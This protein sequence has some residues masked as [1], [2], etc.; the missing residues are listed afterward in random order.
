MEEDLLDRR[1]YVL[2]GF[3]DCCPSDTISMYI[4]SCSH[5]AEHSWEAVSGD[6][7]VVT[8][9]EDIGVSGDILIVAGQSVVE[10]CKKHGPQTF[11][12]VVLTGGGNLN[13]KHIAHIPGPVK[14][15]A[16][17]LKVLQLCESKQ[18]ATV[19]I[20]TIGIGIDGCLPE[21]FAKAMLQGVKV[22]LLCTPFSSLKT[23]FI[24]AFED[25]NYDGIKKYFNKPSNSKNLRAG[26]QITA[27]PVITH[28]LPPNQVKI[29]DALIELKKGNITAETVEAIVNSTNED[30]NLKNG[31]SGA[32]LYAAGSAVEDECAKI[33]PL[34]GNDARLTSGGSLQCDF[35]I[36]I[37][38][39]RNI[40]QAVERV[41]NVLKHCESRWITS[42]SFPAIG[43]GGGGM[44]FPESVTAL[45]LGIKAHLS[46]HEFSA[47]KQ[48]F[49][50]VDQVQA[51]QE[52]Q[53]VL[54]SWTRMTQDTADDDDSSNASS[55]E[56]DCSA[57][58]A[59]IGPV[60]VKLLCG[61]ITEEKTDAIVS[62]TNTS[63]NLKSG[64]SGAILNAAGKAVVDECT[65][66]GNQPG[67]GVVITKPGNLKVKY[68]IHMVGQTKEKDIISSMLKVF[69]MCEDHQIQSVS[70]PALST[71]GGKLHAVDVGNAMV[72]AVEEHIESTKTSSIM[73]VHIVI[74]QTD[75]FQDFLK[76]LMK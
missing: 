53:Q 6:S 17:I 21:D 26:T 39:P 69:K 15:S 5:G 68:I 34:S 71:G 14:I 27:V 20:P 76:S 2:S 64:V 35:I 45:L 19:S 42:V 30:V 8:F 12:N 51:M 37:V 38:G 11:G 52:G 1:R 4:H 28:D 61:D 29:K 10:E 31:V 33:R 67:D 25:R 43:T 18:A 7:I 74:F 22:H 72:T 48:I 23:I 46:K 24:L 63:L 13:C 3:D 40:E 36:H 44:M 57:T 65:N 58:T 16:V 70:F 32:I 75:M 54:R 49:L 55:C 59:E 60:K 9:E 41:K 50:V 66:I 73:D 56:G 47:L 62:S